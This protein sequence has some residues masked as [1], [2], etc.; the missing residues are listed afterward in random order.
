M[1]YV[2][3]VDSNRLLGM[4]FTMTYDLCINKYSNVYPG[5]GF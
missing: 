5:G 2:I 1:C 3:A 4:Q